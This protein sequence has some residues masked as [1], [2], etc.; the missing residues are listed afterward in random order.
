MSES[1]GSYSSWL[2][3]VSV[4]YGKSFLSSIDVFANLRQT[5]GTSK[6]NIKR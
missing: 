3:E 1:D 4:A 2:Y 6:A 5:L